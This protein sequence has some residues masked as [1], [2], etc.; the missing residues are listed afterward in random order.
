[1]SIGEFSVD[2]NIYVAVHGA[3]RKNSV[4]LLN[5]KISSKEIIKGPIIL[6]YKILI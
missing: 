6:N 3:S 5:Q 1:M 4:L 2:G